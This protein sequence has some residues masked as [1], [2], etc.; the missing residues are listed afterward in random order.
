MGMQTT[1]VDVGLGGLLG[2]VYVLDGWRS[3]RDPG[4]VWKSPK[5]RGLSYLL[6][7]GFLQGIRVFKGA[8]TQVL[9]TYTAAFVSV[10]II[11]LCLLSVY[12]YATTRS[13]LGEAM[14]GAPQ[15]R[16]RREAFDQVL[17]LL[18]HGLD[19]FRER[20]ETSVTAELIVQRD[21]TIAFMLAAWEALATDVINVTA[22]NGSSTAGVELFLRFTSNV[23]EQCLKVCVEQSYMLRRFRASVYVLDDETDT[24]RWLSGVGPAD[25]PHSQLPL[26]R[27]ISLADWALKNRGH[28]Q[29]WSKA[30]GTNNPPFEPRPGQT[31]E[32][33]QSVVAYAPQQPDVPLVFSIDCE[34]LGASAYG[35]YLDKMLWVLSV[36]IVEAMRATNVTDEAL[37]AAA[38]PH[39]PS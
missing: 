22:S 6:A 7:G 21:N 32:R 30:D 38:A 18:Q 29:H 34:D 31:P 17:V 2:F 14:P 15:G 16:L 8:S 11:C 4:G 5:V 23:L 24:L 9:V 35:Q 1:F 27:D 25:K 13:R 12:A 37:K 19:D 26:H 10:A 39:S 20:S 36:L 33:Y 3:A 28:A